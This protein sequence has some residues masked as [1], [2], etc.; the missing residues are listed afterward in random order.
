MNE[1]TGFSENFVKIVR[2]HK[3]NPDEKLTAIYLETLSEPLFSALTYK[4]PPSTPSDY[5]DDYTSYTMV[6]DGNKKMEALRTLRGKHAGFLKRRNE[7]EAENASNKY[8]LKQM[9]EHFDK[10]KMT[11]Q[12][13]RCM[14]AYNTHVAKRSKL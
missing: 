6:T 10:I 9:M 12:Y 1:T 14:M 7:I 3:S 2:D 5:D 11:A 8:L 4:Q 13:Q